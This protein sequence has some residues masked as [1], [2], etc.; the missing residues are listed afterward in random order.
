MYK[1]M[2][3]GAGSIGALKDD[4]YDSKTTSEILTH[5]HAIY[6][7][8]NINLTGILETNKSRRNKACRKWECKGYEKLSDRRQKTD[9]IVIACNTEKHREIIDEIVEIK[10]GLVIVEKP[11]CNNL[12][13]ITSAC[14]KLALG[15]IKTIVNYG[16][17]YNPMYKVI[18]RQIKEGLYGKVYSTRITYNRGLLRDGCHAVDLCNMFFGDFQKVEYVSD[19]IIIDNSIDDPTITFGLR[20]EKCDLVSFYGQD[21]NDSAVFDMEIWTQR[22]KLLLANFGAVLRF[23]EVTTKGNKYGS[24]PWLDIN[25][26]NTYNI[27]L[28][29]NLKYLYEDAVNILDGGSPEIATAEDAFKVHEIIKEIKEL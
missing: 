9:I 1:A 28:E 25:N 19:K 22:G 21:G 29:Y 10:P 15:D 5:A 27:D 6:N 11:F 13:E 20:Y 14:T 2:I 17:R 26:T 4:K 7:N 12:E 16:R 3:I 23:T 24:Y 18:A 8:Q